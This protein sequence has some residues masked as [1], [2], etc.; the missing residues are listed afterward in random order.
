[1]DVYVGIDVACAR[2]KRLPVC[3]VGLLD[4]R[5]TPLTIPAVIFRKFPRGPGNGE[6]LKPH[7]FRELAT[8][9]ANA[10]Q[11]LCFAMSCNIKRVAI[12]AP[13][14]APIA[15]PRSCE[16]EMSRHGLSLFQTP[17]VEVWKTIRQIC[18]QHLAQ[19]LP[20]AR[21]PYANKI[22]MLYGFEIFH[23][24]RRANRFEVIEIYPYS[25][26]SE[27]LPECP[28]KSTHEGY[29]SQLMAVAKQTRWLPY[30]LEQLLRT[31]VSGSMHDQLDAFMAAWV[32][33]LSVKRRK[34]YGNPNNPNDAIW[35]P[36]L[37]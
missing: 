2:S 31:C 6:I 14:A 3:I 7:P 36:K 26:V 15:V 21:L 1:M 4:G 5:V 9:L 35:V 28:H 23:A 29:R 10:L 12:D 32:A 8:S 19:K 37:N 34:V 16:L 18:R 11:E 22:W 25:I 27:F 13:A 33:S 20:V 30:D 24:L 17:T